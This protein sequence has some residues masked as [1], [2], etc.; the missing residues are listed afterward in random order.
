M[1]QTTLQFEKPIL[2]ILRPLPKTN[3]K[4]IKNKIENRRNPPI[5]FLDF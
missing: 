2:E 3:R 5:Y 1:K 4:K